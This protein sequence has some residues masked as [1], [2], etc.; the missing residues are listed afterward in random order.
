ML[1]LFLARGSVS[2]ITT[3]LGTVVL[4]L[5]Y[6]IAAGC[7]GSNDDFVD[8]SE[9][10]PESTEPIEISDV[11]VFEN[12]KNAL[13]YFVEW[14]TD[15]PASTVLKMTCGEE[16]SHTY[17]SDKPQRFHSVFVMGLLDGI[18]CD[19]VLESR[20]Y[21][22]SGRAEAS[23]ERAGPLPDFLPE[24]NARIIDR[25][26]MQAGWT[27]WTFGRFSASG[28]VY[29]IVTDEQGRYRWYL[30]ESTDRR[31]ADNELMIIPDGILL[32][33]GSTKILNWEGDVVWEP[34]FESHHDITISTF[35]ENHFL[36]LGYSSKDCRTSEGT[37][38]EFDRTT[39]KTIWTW[40][41]C[42]HFTPRLD[43][44]N[45]SHINT[46][47]PFPDERAVLL[48][49]RDQNAL[50]KVDRDSDAIVWILGEGGDF[51][52]DDSDRFYR[53]HAPEFQPN[54][55]ILLF[56]NG[57]SSSEAS[58]HGDGADKAREYSRALEL[59]LIFDEDGKPLRAEKVWEYK[60]ESLYSGGRS[61]ADRLPNGNTLIT[62]STLEEDF[63]T[64]MREVTAE[65]EVVWELR[66]PEDRSTYRS[67]R[68]TR[69]YFGYVRDDAD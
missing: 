52:M 23:I 22:R 34:P 5:I 62:Y 49:P 58:R 38:N 59:A 55:N 63:S 11:A 24:L 43:Y 26:R 66:A 2:R 16:I 14:K 8:P 17:N 30:L 68:L 12:P 10:D 13:S 47:E 18:S 19:L 15:I 25:E 40:Y 44:K 31:Y 53:Q 54:G 42:E 32:G 27:L 33:G 29:V 9:I 57:L 48:S 37:A 36:Y 69:E 35:H 6:C 3:S 20:I 28:P 64:L 39:Q 4:A 1:K 45:W 46:I 21:Q 51:E 7:D 41:I 56:D 61:E 65:G 67:E 60:D 50:L